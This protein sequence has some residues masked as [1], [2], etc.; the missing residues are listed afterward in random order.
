MV[1]EIVESLKVH[2]TLKTGQI[3]ASVSFGKEESVVDID[4]QEAAQRF[5]L[6]MQSVFSRKTTFRQQPVM[7]TVS[8]RSLPNVCLPL[9][10]THV[11][12][13][14]MGVFCHIIGDSTQKN[15]D[16]VIRYGVAFSEL[17]LRSK[18]TFS[19]STVTF[20]VSPQAAKAAGSNNICPFS[21]AKP[22]GA[23]C[24]RDV[25]GGRG[26]QYGHITK[27]N[28]ETVYFD[29]GRS[30]VLLQPSQTE[31]FQ[32]VDRYVSMQGRSQDIER[33]NIAPHLA[34]EENEI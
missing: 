19:V 26:E 11:R 4:V 30:R 14:A 25:E 31:S 23:I 3:I 27:I 10:P 29:G 1:S 24:R 8:F 28:W 22:N 12:W 21:T 18:A 17:D 5:L 32:D 34:E 33:S 15:L 2:V 16:T 9:S 7:V 20:D 6:T 13:E